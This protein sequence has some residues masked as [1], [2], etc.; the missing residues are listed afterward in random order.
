MMNEQTN[1]NPIEAINEFYRL[2]DKYESGYYEKYIKPIIK[3]NKSKKEK[4]VDFSKLPKHECINCKRN[5][6]TMFSI[7]FDDKEG[8][9]HFKAKCGD[10]QDPCPLDIEIVCS[11]REQMNKVIREGL[12]EIEQIKLRI[13]REKNNALFFNKDVVSV[14][15]KITQELKAETENTGFI[16]E[17]N[18][19]RNDNPEKYNLLKLT[20]DEFGEGF[21]LP[22]KQ[23]IK[24]YDGTN[25]LLILHQATTFYINEIIPKLREIQSLKY[26]VNL[27]EFDETKNI[28]R[29]IQLPN[30]LENNEFFIKSDDKVVKFIRGIKKSKSKTRKEKEVTILKPKNKTKKI[31]PVAELVLEED[32]EELVKPIEEEPKLIGGY[33][34]MNEEKVIE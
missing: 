31:K 26:N 34:H 2:K 1:L 16:I 27:V 28:Y 32:E 33:D 15:E 13:I 30:S 29:L 11:S 10:I 14:F 12:A 19:I 24:E 23:M 6:G 25:N 7:T 17:T 18:I 22:F 5:V 8:I 4:R 3:S 20:I 21:I 9:K